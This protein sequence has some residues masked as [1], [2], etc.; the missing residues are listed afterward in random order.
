VTEGAGSGP[1]FAISVPRLHNRR[2]NNL[3]LRTARFYDLDMSDLATHDLAFYRRYTAQSGG[4]VLELAC[5]TGRVTIP[6]A[7]AGHRVHGVD[8]SQSMLEILDEKVRRLAPQIRER[9]S[10]TPG[11]MAEFAL[12]MRFSTV[13]IPFRAFQA[14]TSFEQQRGCL[15]AVKRHLEPGGRFILNVFMPHP[16][17][18]QAWE[19]PDDR[20]DWVAHDP[21]TGETI[22]R[23][24]RRTR[25]DPGRQIIYPE[26]TFEVTAHDGSMRTFT[27]QL[28]LRYFYPYQIQTLLLTHGFKIEEEWGDYH[29]S[30]LGKGPE[31]VFVCTPSA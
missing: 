1:E 21:K 13:L 18:I 17:I 9:I 3:F 5:G 2:V 8:L 30:P 22:T 28:A 6:L 24:S 29:R 14:L 15:Q 31:Q 23:R 27:D 20:V 4:P 16:R 10:F 12:Q 25:I 19:S 26:L 7:R 11:D